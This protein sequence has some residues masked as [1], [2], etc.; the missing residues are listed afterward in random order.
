MVMAVSTPVHIKHTT[1]SGAVS[2][3]VIDDFGTYQVKVAYTDENGV[4]QERFFTE[5]QIEAA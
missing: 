4:D 2:G 5:D 3:G 1:L